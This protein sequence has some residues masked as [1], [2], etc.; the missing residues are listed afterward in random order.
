MTC[1]CT[2]RCFVTGYC[3][4]AQAIP[5]VGKIEVTTSCVGLTPKQM[6]EKF[7]QKIE[8]EKENERLKAENKQLSGISGQLKVENA[9]LKAQ[10]ED[11]KLR[12][13]FAVGEVSY[14]QK[15]VRE[16][17]EQLKTQLSPDVCSKCLKPECL[18]RAQLQNCDKASQVEL[19]E[20]SGIELG[21][22]NI[23]RS[24]KFATS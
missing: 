3:E 7:Q 23:V 22:R 12:Y 24:E 8:L 13:K 18:C 10:L 17:I 21:D 16:E 9:Q 4:A 6:L 1:N 5:G 19:C 2:G 14:I 11:E 20:H 15:I